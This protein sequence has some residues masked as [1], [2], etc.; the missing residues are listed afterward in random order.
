MSE[1]ISLTKSRESIRLTKGIDLAKGTTPDILINLNWNHAKPPKGFFS[2]LFGSG[3]IDLDIGALYELKNG[4]KGVIQA[5]G[6]EWGD[7][8]QTPFIELDGDDRTGQSVGGENI[9]INGQHWAEIKRLVIYAFIYKGAPNWNATDGVVTVVVPGEAPVEVRMT[10]GQNNKSLCGIVLIENDGGQI[11]ITR[12][13][14]YFRDQKELDHA[15]RWGL[16]WVH[17]SK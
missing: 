5:L 1:T 17:G 9:R 13:V 2:S 16:E 10:S 6:E 3:S 14:D 8:D 11:K 15:H 4:N 12:V 7:F